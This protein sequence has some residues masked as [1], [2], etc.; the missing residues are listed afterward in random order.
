MNNANDLI[1]RSA[2]KTEI[3]KLMLE[4]AD[5]PLVDEYT[6]KLATKLGELVMKKLDE[7]P[8][9]PE[10]RKLLQKN[11]LLE[12][13]HTA[14]LAALR[15]ADQ[16][17]AFCAGSKVNQEACEAADY[18][19]ENC[20]AVCICRACRGNSN[21]SWCGMREENDSSDL[22]NCSCCPFDGADTAVHLDSE[23]LG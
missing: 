8:E 11:Q 2:A 17:C 1:C 15:Q 14:L 20:D 10:Q 18:G 13:K 7:L 6:A 23:R 3:R 22:D 9:A 21:W 12:R 19:C 16:D 5:T 4:V